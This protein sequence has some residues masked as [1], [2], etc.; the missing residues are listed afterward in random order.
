MPEP[1]DA[2]VT[3]PSADKPRKDRNRLEKVAAAVAEEIEP[4]A[5]HGDGTYPTYPGRDPIDRN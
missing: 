2:K 4:P 5:W 1:K 3:G